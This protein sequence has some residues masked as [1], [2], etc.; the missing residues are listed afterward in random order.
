[1]NGETVLRGCRLIDGTGLEPQIDA[2]VVFAGG[3]IRQAGPVDTLRF[4]RREVVSEKGA[5]RQTR[6]LWRWFIGVALV[7]LLGEWW[8][9]SRRAWS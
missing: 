9:Y 5:V 6:E 8:I 4:G 7:V 2:G 1:M 3:I